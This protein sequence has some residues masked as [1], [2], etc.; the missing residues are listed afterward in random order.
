MSDVNPFNSEYLLI[1]ESCFDD[2]MCPDYTPTVWMRKA[3]YMNTS[4][5]TTSLGEHTQIIKELDAKQLRRIF[6]QIRKKKETYISKE[7]SMAVYRVI[8][9]MEN[10]WD[11][12]L[13]MR[14]DKMK[15]KMEADSEFKDYVNQIKAVP[16]F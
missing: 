2:N 7:T 16:I 12:E 11:D 3:F 5:Y 10:N 4:L 1:E 8:Y 13:N 15:E 6:S 14:A 9:T